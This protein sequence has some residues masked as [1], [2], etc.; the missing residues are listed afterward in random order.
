MAMATVHLV[1]A[2]LPVR[3]KL[4][5]PGKA[6]PLSFVEQAFGHHRTHVPTVKRGLPA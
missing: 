3:K 4:V 6:A 5:D 2:N 1:T